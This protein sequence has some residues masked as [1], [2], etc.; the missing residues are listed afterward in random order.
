MPMTKLL[1]ALET[2]AG[3]KNFLVNDDFECASTYAKH[4]RG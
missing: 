3:T 2:F 4:T 1:V